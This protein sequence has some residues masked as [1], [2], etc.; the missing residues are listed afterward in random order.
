MTFER[1]RKAAWGITLLVAAL[2]SAALRNHPALGI[3]PFTVGMIEAVAFICI[4]MAAYKASWQASVVIALITPL[5][6]WAQ[7]FLDGYMIP[8][9]MLVGLALT[10]CMM[11]VIRKNCGFLGAVIVMALP[12]FVVLLAGTAAALWAVKQEG[13]LRALVGAWNTSAYTG[14]SMLGAA[15]FCGWISKK[16]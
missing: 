8:V 15:V 14:V 10:G 7:K 6:L 13:I 5:F 4:L 12:A 1:G 11:L 9:H 2:G 16:R 3:M